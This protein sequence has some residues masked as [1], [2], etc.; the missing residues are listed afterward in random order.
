MLEHLHIA[1]PSVS[2]FLVVFRSKD[3]TRES[4]EQEHQ[5]MILT[6]P[7]RRSSTGQLAASVA[8]VATVA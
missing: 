2:V 4:I 3:G 1:A 5:K 8:T 7:A 6:W